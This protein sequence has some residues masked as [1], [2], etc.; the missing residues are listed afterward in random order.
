M[1][2]F[3]TGTELGH[4]TAGTK[5][6]AQTLFEMSVSSHPAPETLHKAS[7]HLA[8]RLNRFVVLLRERRPIHDQ[9]PR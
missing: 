4:F 9:R 8:R 1:G 6:N 2:H 7:W 5:Q 3:P